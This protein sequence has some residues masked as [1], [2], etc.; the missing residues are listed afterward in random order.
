MQSRDVKIYNILS[1]FFIYEKM[2]GRSSLLPRIEMS[3][4]HVGI[5]FGTFISIF[6]HYRWDANTDDSFE[7]SRH[8]L[9]S[10]Q[11]RS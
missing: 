7:V 5:E 6:T 4:S 10:Q 1:F 2:T 3:L 9:F 11:C 8:P